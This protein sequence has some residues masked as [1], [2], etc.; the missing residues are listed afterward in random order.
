MGNRRNNRGNK[1]AAR[2]R[3][4][5]DSTG[6]PSATSSNAGAPTTGTAKPAKSGGKVLPQKEVD[7][8]ATGRNITAKSESKEASNKQAA[9]GGKNLRKKKGSSVAVAEASSGAVATTGA[10]SAV[11]TLAT[12][13]SPLPTDES[14]DMPKGDKEEK[15]ETASGE[16]TAQSAEQLTLGGKTFV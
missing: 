14:M 7:E 15:N 3:K 6:N 16:A 10:N 4:P 5:D 11:H 12:G 13:T 9:T 2:T 1:E 8:E